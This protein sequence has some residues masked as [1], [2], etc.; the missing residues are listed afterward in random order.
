MTWG[1]MDCE[2]W[3]RLNRWIEQNG[4]S[5]YARYFNFNVG[6]WQTRRFYT[7][8]ASCSPVRPGQKSGAHPGV[9]LYLEN[10][11]LSVYDMGEVET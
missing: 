11:T 5:F 8:G 6:E 7:E 2:T 4:M 3:W 10:C 9:P 1:R